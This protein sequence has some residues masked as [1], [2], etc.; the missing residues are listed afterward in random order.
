MRALLCFLLLSLLRAAAHDEPTSYV[1]FVPAPDGLTVR[2]AAS[3][4]DFAHYLPAMDAATLLRPDA[5]KVQQPALHALVQQRLRLQ[6]LTLDPVSAEPVPDKSDL[7]L[8][9]H[10]VWAAEPATLP[11]E[12]RLFP[13]DPRHRTFVTVRRDG[14]VEST[15]IFH[16]SAAAAVVSL[17]RPQ[18]ILS[19]MRQFIAEGIHHI[20]IGPDHILFVIGLLL[21]GGGVR[22]LLKIITAFTLAHSIT[23]GLATF[24]IF[25][26]PAAVIEPVIA[27]S[28]VF[29]G[30]HAILPGERRDPRLIFAF[31]FGLIHGFGFAFALSEL[32]LPRAALGWSLLAFNGGVEAGQACIVLAVAPV[33]AIV[34]QYSQRLSERV[35]TACAACVIMAGTFWFVE[36][37]MA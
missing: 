35:V 37:I 4:T 10:A 32:N 21:L 3:A 36:R 11:V 31:L 13:Y 17:G 1:D 23:L 29:V 18:G 9:F 25:T 27:L 7:L 16:D 14:T 12:C 6:G 20:F 34:R 8:V 2:L 26:P 15:A 30:I 22:R 33:L 24:Q 28:I 19:A 5:L